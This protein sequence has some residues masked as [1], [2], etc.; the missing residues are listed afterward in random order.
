M[1]TEQLSF[2][3]EESRQAGIEQVVGKLLPSLMKEVCQ[4]ALKLACQMEEFTAED[5]LNR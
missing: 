4:V 3:K 1:S 5:A 2:F